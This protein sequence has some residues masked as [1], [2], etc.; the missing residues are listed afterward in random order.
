MD[1]VHIFLNFHTSPVVWDYFDMDRSGGEE[2]MWNFRSILD[3]LVF[4]TFP[5]WVCTRFILAIP[6]PF[7]LTRCLILFIHERLLRRTLFYLDV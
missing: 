5:H 7:F 6:T 2:E 4:V 3:R 1:D